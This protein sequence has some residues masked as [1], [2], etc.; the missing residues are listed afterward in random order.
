VP[1]VSVI[2]PARDTAATIG[3]T[4]DALARQR[5]EGSFEVI[6]VIDGHDPATAA[7]AAGSATQ[8]RV[9]DASGRDAHG[10]GAAR[11]R[12]AAAA[13]AS[14]LAFTDAD[15]E[16]APDWL[17]RGLRA[18]GGADLVQGAVRPVPGVEIGP[19][20]RT[21][22]VRGES[23]LFET[24]NLL[25]RRELFAR[26]GGF[27]DWIAARG[28]P[29]GEDVWF[30]WRARRAGARVVFAADAVVHHAVFRRGA[31]EFIAEHARRRF[32]P[33]MARRIPELRT[34]F[35]YRRWFLSR[36]SAAFDVAL[37][38]AVAAAAKRSPMPLAAALPYVALLRRNG[39][40][41]RGAE[42]ARVTMANVAADSVSLAALM[43][44]SVGART[45]LL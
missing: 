12:G 25:V 17:A 21:V 37:V 32:F 4:L 35:F 38:G 39:L 6:V 15:C 10:A 8:P 22:A 33:P 11:N 3:R 19:Y 14:V 20:D 42:A 24:A 1:D 5:L 2:I 18:L 26:L 40:S 34:A 13:N 36:R 9:L 43:W 44:G 23:G 27:E 41:L 29:M 45:L 16:P 30:G 28:R 31:R 7:A